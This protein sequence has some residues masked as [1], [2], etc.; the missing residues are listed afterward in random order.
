LERL[1]QTLYNNYFIL[2][3]LFG[4]SAVVELNNDFLEGKGYD[5]K[6]ITHISIKDEQTYFGLYDLWLIKVDA[7]T[8]K[9]IKDEAK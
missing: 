2:S 7:K 8:T 3:D 5:F 9:V 1:N 6:Y 4:D